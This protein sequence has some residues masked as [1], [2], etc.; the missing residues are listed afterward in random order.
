VDA[1][2]RASLAVG[3]TLVL[4]H[5]VATAR[6][7]LALPEALR[8]VVGA[9]PETTLTRPWALFAAPLFHD[10]LGHLGYNLLV[11]ALAMPPALQ[12]VGTG[13]GL[14]AA[15]LASPL[16]SALVNLALIL[17]LASL[18]WG[19]A[20]AA[21]D[22][23]LVGASVVVFASAGIALATRDWSTATLLGVALGYVAYEAVLA[24]T[25][26][27]RPFVGVYHVTGFGTGLMAVQV[28]LV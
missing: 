18:G 10:D 27:T 20:Q 8:S 21:V 25:G 1:A 2:H 19:W 22:P 12:A 26:T 6:N 3:A 17:P 15:Y 9:S 5:L 11:L 13:R 7:G 14:A 23:R 24:A 4:V 28:G 16:S